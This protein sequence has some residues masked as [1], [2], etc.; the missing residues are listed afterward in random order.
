MKSCE[1]VDKL[2][3]ELGVTDDASTSGALSSKRLNL[4]KKRRARVH[5]HQPSEKKSSS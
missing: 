3:N 5:M 1:S 2:A 4:A